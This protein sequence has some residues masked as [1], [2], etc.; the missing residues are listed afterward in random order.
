MSEGDV[1]LTLELCVKG[2]H[3]SSP[4]ITKEIHPALRDWLTVI[5]LPQP[6]QTITPHA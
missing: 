4:K 5:F 1:R 2:C 3:I 6:Q